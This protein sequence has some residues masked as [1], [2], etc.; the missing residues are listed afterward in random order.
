MLY[1]NISLF[2]ICLGIVSTNPITFGLRFLIHNSALEC[3]DEDAQWKSCTKQEVCQ[4]QRGI[5]RVDR[6][7]IENW[8][9]RLDV[10]C[11][12][13]NYF[14]YSLALGCLLSLL[15]LPFTF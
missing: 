11:T 3:Q 1:Q 7:D 6:N 2:M 4:L 8:S 10:L 13:P 15:V 5:F 14:A 9:E 12:D